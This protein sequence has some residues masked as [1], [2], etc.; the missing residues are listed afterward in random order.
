M[1]RWLPCACAVLAS[2]FLLPSCR[3]PAAPSPCARQTTLAP[4]PPPATATPA[5]TPSGSVPIENW[6]QPPTEY[7]GDLGTFRSPL[8]FYDGSPVKTPAEWPRRRA[9]IR[10]AWE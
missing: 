1:R 9:E 4:P 3:P 2:I 5:S 10:E 8:K 6:F 7:A